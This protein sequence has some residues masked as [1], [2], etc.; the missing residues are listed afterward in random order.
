[1]Q[2]AAAK[3]TAAEGRALSTEG[4]FDAYVTASAKA[5]PIQD[6]SRQML[7]ARI[8]QQLPWQGLRFETG[9]RRQVSVVTSQ[10]GARMRLNFSLQPI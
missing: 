2:A 5:Y 7:D 9:W 4:A 6:Q 10:D 1:M 8:Q 3:V